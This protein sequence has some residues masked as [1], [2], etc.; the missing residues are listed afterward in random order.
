[1]TL[2]VAN[3]QQCIM[4]RRFS[5]LLIPVLALPALLLGQRPDSSRGASSASAWL[6]GG[7]GWYRGV[8]LRQQDNDL[9]DYSG[10]LGQRSLWIASHGV[11]VGGRLSR[12]TGA[13][14][15]LTPRDERSLLI[16]GRRRSR[17]GYAMIA[18]GIAR[19]KFN[20]YYQDNSF[21][22]QSRHARDER[23][24]ALGGELARTG[25][26]AGIGVSLVGVNTAGERYAALTAS[27]QLGW[28]K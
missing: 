27:L 23:G 26:Y 3:I 22:A 19:A 5:V 11:V 4:N 24:L 20:D 12:G 28:L 14:G 2:L 15:S 6:S 7:L 8:K 17:T 9:N 1:M 16:G 18:A 25:K 13:R 21:S 10:Y